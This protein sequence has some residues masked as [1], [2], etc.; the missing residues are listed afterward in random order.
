MRLLFH[1]NRPA[2]V[3]HL[4]QVG[5]DLI[6][7]CLRAFGIL[8]RNSAADGQR[9]N[10]FPARP[11][12]NPASKEQHHRVRGELHARIRGA[13]LLELDGGLAQNRGGISFAAGAGHRLPVASVTNREQPDVPKSVDNAHMNRHMLGR[14]GVDGCLRSLDLNAQGQ[15]LLG[16]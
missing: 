5:L 13:L 4:F 9:A 7:S 1:C 2:S 14:T 15:R 16:Q 8:L 3:T 6:Q 10:H 12:G 11:D